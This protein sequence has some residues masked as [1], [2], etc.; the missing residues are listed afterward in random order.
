MHWRTQ[1][2]VEFPQDLASLFDKTG[3]RVAGS[4]SA[5][6]EIEACATITPGFFG[7]SDL[8]ARGGSR[9][10]G[11]DIAGCGPVLGSMKEAVFVG[12]RA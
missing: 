4:G 1:R 6:W 10:A 3:R 5:P 9:P 8:V 11:G 2:S 7:W 12:H